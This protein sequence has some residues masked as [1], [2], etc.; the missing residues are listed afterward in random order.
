[1]SKLIDLTGEKFGNITILSRAENAKD[2][3]AQW[4][5]Q[6]ICG[7]NFIRK[8]T[9]IRQSFKRNPNYSCGCQQKTTAKD[10]TGQRFGKLIA[11]KPTEERAIGGQN[12]IWEFQC[13]CGRITKIST[14]NIGHT[15]SC[16]KCSKISQGELKIEQILKENNISFEREK[17]FKNFKY[18]NGATPRFDFYVTYNNI[19]YLIEYDGEQHFTWNGRG[20][21]TED[22]FNKIQ[23]YDKIKNQYCKENNISLIRIPYTHLNNIVL[24]DLLL[25]T[26]QFII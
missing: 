8:G 20:W 26:S 3:T 1:M 4:N 21:N 15:N 25:K 19:N 23:E 12:I 5:C 6:C 7:K 2:G 18:D 10:I 24:E 14:A 13:D 22:Y 11:L 9:Q 16:G 17:N